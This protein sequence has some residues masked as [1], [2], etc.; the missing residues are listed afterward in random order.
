MPARVELSAS[1]AV[2]SP[3]SPTV[4]DLLE[5]LRA[6]LD[7]A[8]ERAEDAAGVKRH[9]RSA[10]VGAHGAYRRL[11]GL[12]ILVSVSAAAAV[13]TV[14]VAPA[15]NQERIPAEPR[16]TDQL[17]EQQLGA[18]RLESIGRAHDESPPSKAG[19]GGG[20]GVFTVSKANRQPNWSK[21][22][23][24]GRR[25]AVY[26]LLLPD[27]VQRVQIH[28]SDGSVVTRTVQDNGL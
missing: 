5:D 11:R 21:I 8:F 12:M 23:L 10:S 9:R 18:R 1:C 22:F 27:G 19:A 14:V 16:A 4:P 15:L 6:E 17:P 28:H 26:T 20:C 25:G 24:G 3:R 7:S 13:F 2:I